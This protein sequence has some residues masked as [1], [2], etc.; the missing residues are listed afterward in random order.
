MQNANTLINGLKG[1]R[2]NAIEGIR[3]LLLQTK[4]K[5]VVF[6]T[7]KEIDADEDDA[8]EP[9]I[10]Y[11]T[12]VDDYYVQNFILSVQ[13][14]KDNQVEISIYDKTSYTL[15]VEILDFF[16]DM[17]DFICSLYLEV[18]KS[19]NDKLKVSKFKVKITEDNKHRVCDKCNTHLGNEG[20]VINGGHKYYCSDECLHQVYSKEQWEEMYEDGGDSYWTEW[21]DEYEDEITANENKYFLFG[22]N[23]VGI[24]EKFGI[25]G[26]I[27]EIKND[28]PLNYDMCKFEG[29]NVTELMNLASA[30]GAEYYAEISEEDYLLIQNLNK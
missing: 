3:N 23:V 22:M 20:Y 19:L 8:I 26:I 14:N 21:E 2:E 12:K 7:Q 1:I 17:T 18:E 29:T 9:M 15:D 6:Y 25:E 16:T 28:I 27:K 4:N 5:K 13:L 30:Y 24:L 11:D 10:T